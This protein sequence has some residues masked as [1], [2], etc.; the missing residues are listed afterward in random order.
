M[1]AHPITVIDDAYNA[2]P[3]SMM[4][5]VSQLSDSVLPG[6]KVLVLGEMAEL[7]DGYDQYYRALVAHIARSKIDTIY[8]I[9]QTYQDYAGAISGAQRCILLEGVDTFR[10]SYLRDIQDGDTVLF[11]GSHSANIWKLVNWLKLLASR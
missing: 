6:R 5:A 9:G 1:A 3:G 11:K 8:L 2:N 4:M 10:T 7:G